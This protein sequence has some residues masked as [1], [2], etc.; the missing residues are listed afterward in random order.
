[1]SQDASPP[2]AGGSPEPSG[3]PDPK[4]AAPESA[5]VD[6]PEALDAFAELEAQ[7]ETP[8]AASER[9]PLV[10]WDLIVTIVLIALMLVG[11]A[12]ATVASL[13]LVVLGSCT[14][15]AACNTTLQGLGFLVALVLPGLVGL[16]FAGWAVV[17]LWRRRLAYWVPIVGLVAVFVPLALGAWIVT[18]GSS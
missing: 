10:L 14:E 4:Q 2:P 15:A 17:R 3:G 9:A 13:G 1:M 8:V 12:A 16:V 6:G 7:S 11:A 5:I 18:L